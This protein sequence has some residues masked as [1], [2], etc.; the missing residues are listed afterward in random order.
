M[1]QVLPWRPPLDRRPPAV[2]ALARAVRSAL[3]AQ[4]PHAL[5]PSDGMRQWSEVSSEPIALVELEWHR[6]IACIVKRRLMTSWTFS[7]SARMHG[8][9]FAFEGGYRRDVATGAFY[10]FE[11]S[12][13]DRPSS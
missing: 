1:S 3:P 10:E 2:R 11:L 13:V 7:G 8:R 9:V 5:L 6:Q 12:A 4:H